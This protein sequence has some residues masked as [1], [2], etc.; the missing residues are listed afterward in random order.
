MKVAAVMVVSAAV[1][2]SAIG[3]ADFLGGMPDLGAPARNDTRQMES[4]TCDR[5]SGYGNQI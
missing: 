1:A 3:F 2:V 4:S 5:L